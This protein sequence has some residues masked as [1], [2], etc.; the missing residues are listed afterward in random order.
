MNF[1]EEIQNLKNF[2]INEIEPENLG[3]LPELIKIISYVLVFI[4][5]LFLGHTLYLSNKLDNLDNTINKEN[6]IK[7]DFQSKAF[8][9]KNLDSYKEQLEFLQ[10][11]FS[12]ILSQLPNDTEVPSIL[13]DISYLGSASGLSFE[14][15]DLQPEVAHEFYIEL[16]IKIKLTGDYHAIGVFVSGVANLPRIVTIHDFLLEHDSQADIMSMELLAKTY[17]YNDSRAR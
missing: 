4:L 14:F 1:S 12:E 9:I 13:E 2:D 5:I 16:P 17:R 15:I 3:S 8:K 7:S 6:N 10:V 11:Q